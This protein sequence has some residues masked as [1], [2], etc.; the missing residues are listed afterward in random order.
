MEE[1]EDRKSRFSM[2]FTSKYH[3]AAF[4]TY[5]QGWTYQGTLRLT[6]ITSSCSNHSG[7]SVKF[8]GSEEG[9]RGVVGVRRA[10]W[11]QDV[12][13]VGRIG[14]TGPVHFTPS[15]SGLQVL[16]FASFSQ[17]ESCVDAPTAGMKY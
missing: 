6:T 13:V 9:V 12:V 11:M 5:R 10:G 17:S 16:A 7:M 8:D 4:R 1:L 3:S 2:R 14:G 15:S